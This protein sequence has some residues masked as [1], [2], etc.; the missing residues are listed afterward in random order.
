CPCHRVQ[1]NVELQATF[2]FFSFFGSF[3]TLKIHG[4]ELINRWQ[5][6]SCIVKERL[7]FA[8]EILVNLYIY[9]YIYIYMRVC[10]CVRVRGTFPVL[11]QTSDRLEGQE[12]HLYL[13]NGFGQL[14]GI[15]S[16]LS[17]KSC[18]CQQ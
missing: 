12:I 18:V 15:L 14:F 13:K 1:L 11:P 6:T 8:R 7:L 3:H 2:V 17:C 4:S 10:V 16:H 9:I 5:N